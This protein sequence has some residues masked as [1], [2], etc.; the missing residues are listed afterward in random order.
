[1]VF[2][3]VLRQIFMRSGSSRIMNQSVT[4]N[5]VYLRKQFEFVILDDY[6]YQM[7]N[8]IKIEHSSHQHR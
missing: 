3:S 5:V 7:K 1:M 8:G 2:S 6:L 4:L